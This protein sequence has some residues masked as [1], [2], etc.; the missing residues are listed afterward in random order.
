MK[1]AYYYF[2]ECG[3]LVKIFLIAGIVTAVIALIFLL[4]GGFLPLVSDTFYFTVYNA[5]FIFFL[6][7]SIFSFAV[8]FCIHKICTDVANLLKEAEEKQRS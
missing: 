8:T 3:Q 7:I 4:K 2:G 5:W 6:S 1:K